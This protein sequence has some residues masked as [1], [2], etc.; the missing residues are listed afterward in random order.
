M[1]IQSIRR[2]VLIARAGRC[3]PGRRRPSSPGDSSPA[4]PRRVASW[5]FG[6]PAVFGAHRPGCST[7]PT[8]QQAQIK[9]IL[10]SSRRRDRGAASRLGMDAHAARST[11]RVLAQPVDEAAIRAAGAASSA[12]V[13]GRR[14]ASLF[15]QVR[16]EILPLL[17]RRPASRRSQ[18]F[19]AACA[20][21]RATA[22]KSLEA[23]LTRSNLR[24]PAPVAATAPGRLPAPLG[25]P[26]TRRLL[27][28][29]AR[30]RRPGRLRGARPPGRAVGARR[31]SPRDRRP[32]ARG[33]RRPGSA[34]CGH[35]GRSPLPPPDLRSP[36]GCASIAVNARDRPRAPAPRR[37]P[38]S[39]TRRRPQRGE[40]ARGRWTC[41]R[42]RSRALAAVDREIM[43]ARELEGI[44]DRGDRA[45]ASD[46]T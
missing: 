46:M 31:G 23:F 5:R 8:D 24:V 6:P 45:P 39:R 10:K 7:C 30:R 43:L 25:S 19:A 32:G 12:D 14:S 28:D 44:G 41:S 1:S 18:C 27:V 20:S 13:H 21:P 9:E 2:S 38:A 35:S 15:A 34:S 42:R 22:V 3:G 11:T 26:A 17:T 40:A 37:V 4:P 16:A 36:P 33:G 29:R